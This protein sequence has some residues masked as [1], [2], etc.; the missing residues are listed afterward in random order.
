MQHVFNLENVAELLAKALADDGVF[1]LIN[2]DIR[3]VPSNK[4][5]NVFWGNDGKDINKIIPQYFKVE[6]K[7]AMP[8]D[9]CDAGAFL[10]KLTKK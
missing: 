5:G 4:D 8:L 10:W 1:Y 7:S 6:F 3:C 9:L 2:R